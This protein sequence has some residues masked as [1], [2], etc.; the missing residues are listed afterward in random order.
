[1]WEKRGVASTHSNRLYLHTVQR[2]WPAAHTYPLQCL[3]CTWPAELAGPTFAQKCCPMPFLCQT[4][5]EILHSTSHL[6]TIL[7]ETLKEPVR[8]LTASIGI[9]YLITTTPITAGE[10]QSI[11]FEHLDYI[12]FV[13]KK[14][15][16]K[17]EHLW[18]S[19]SLLKAIRMKD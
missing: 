6:R 14:M 19:N 2:L 18:I 5:A 17:K 9:A 15:L 11:F 13:P 12:N 10:W 1:M 4:H 16:S 3:M 7:M 8:C